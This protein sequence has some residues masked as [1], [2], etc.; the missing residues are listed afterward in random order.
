MPYKCKLNVRNHFI[1][2]FTMGIGLFE[3]VIFF[4]TTATTAHRVSV[5][6]SPPP[7]EPDGF[8][9][10]PRSRSQNFSDRGRFGS[11][12]SSSATILISSSA[13]FSD[14]LL[15]SLLGP[16]FDAD[17]GA[18]EGYR[19]LLVR[20]ITARGLDNAWILPSRR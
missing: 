15:W 13:S 10:S 3:K 17:E 2:L 19:G 14:S 9:S 8:P 6:P 20:T 12:S 11:L 4:F 16:I 7:F 1:V 18:S 5:A